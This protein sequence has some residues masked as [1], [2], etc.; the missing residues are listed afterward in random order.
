MTKGEINEQMNYWKISGERNWKATE[1]V[2]KKIEKKITDYIRILRADKLP[3]REVILFGS[4]AKGKQREYSDI[5]LCVISPKFKDP[6]DAM[7]YLWVKRADDN[8]P[9]IEPV[10]FSLKD[11]K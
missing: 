6:F 1:R 9:T 4:Y 11:F 7:Q 5:D 3:I 10:G 8:T 2:P